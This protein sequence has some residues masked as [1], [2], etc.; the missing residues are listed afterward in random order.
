MINRG[1][2][3]SDP[4]T[5]YRADRDLLLVVLKSRVLA[6]AMSVLGFADKESQPSKLPLPADITKQPKIRRLQY[7]Q[8]AAALIVDKFVFND[9]VVNRLLDEILTSQQ[10]QDV[11]DQRDR[12]TDG[13]FPCRFPGCQFSFKYDGASRRRHELTHDP[14]P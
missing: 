11:Q 5:A 1:N 13:R 6:A 9:D 14:P 4:H 8:E 3:K 2:V 10:T 12:T 7:L